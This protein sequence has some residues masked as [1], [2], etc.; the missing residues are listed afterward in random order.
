MTRNEAMELI[1]RIQFIPIISE[2]NRKL[3]SELYKH[4][5]ESSDPLEWVKVIKSC[6]VQIHFTDKVSISEEDLIYGN[7]AKNRLEY[8]FSKALDIKKEEVEE[9]I[10]KYIDENI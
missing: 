1:D 3:R 4:S 9:Y 10:K 8:E 2:N 5:A 7:H 6:Y